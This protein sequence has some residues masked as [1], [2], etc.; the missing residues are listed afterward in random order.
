MRGVFDDDEVEEAKPR[1]DTE[2]TLGVGSLVLLF[3]GLVL[4]CGLCFGLG[5][6]VGRHHGAAP[7]AAA[8]LLPAA[9]AQS[10]VQANGSLAKP[11]AT[12]QAVV[13]PPVGSAAPQSDA[14][15]PGGAGPP[16]STPP[17]QTSGQAEAASAQTL[18]RPALPIQANQVQVASASSAA[19]ALP[20]AA[21]LMVQIAAVSHQEDAD[22]LVA[23][24]RKHGYA[25]S[26]RRE[27]ADNLIH[28][29]IGPFNNRDEANR[30]RIKLLD[31]GYNAMIQP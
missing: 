9:G 17:L 12:A 22:V 4:V 18:V 25:V 11:S 19:P 13:A 28:V 24:L 14:A 10:P 30:W 7:D 21:Q 3:M 31:D 20:I 15:Q 8:G 27:P 5:Y 29:R 16:Q 1:R 6:S 26:A 2:L 23:A